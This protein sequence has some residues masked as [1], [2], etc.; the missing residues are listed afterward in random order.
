[1]ASVTFANLDR[2]ST[3]LF[4]L[5]CIFVIHVLEILDDTIL[6]DKIASKFVYFQLGGNKN[7][8]V[9]TIKKVLVAK[10]SNVLV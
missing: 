2:N 6:D 10:R 7:K 9:F 8:R 3:D 1:M 4:Q 5:Q